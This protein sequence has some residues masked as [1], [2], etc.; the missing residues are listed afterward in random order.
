MPRYFFDIAEN[1][2]PFW[3]ND[4]TDLKNIQK[5]REDAIGALLGMAQS[6]VSLGDG[7]DMAA[8]VRDERG[9]VVATVTLT[10]EVSTAPPTVPS[11]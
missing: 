4:G 1:G 6:Y 5:V 2:Q 11:S 9:A 8:A 7:F 3:D 10:I